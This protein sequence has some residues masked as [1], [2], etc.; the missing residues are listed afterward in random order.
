MLA[1]LTGPNHGALVPIAAGA[2]HERA[3]RRPPPFRTVWQANALTVAH[4]A[5]LVARAKSMRRACAVASLP[6]EVI[7]LVL[8]FIPVAYSVS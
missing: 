7:A 3:P 1:G 5:R 2:G 4:F 8:R 6:D